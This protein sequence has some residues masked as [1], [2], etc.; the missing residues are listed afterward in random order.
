MS[1]D[2]ARFLE[3]KKVDFLR[4][5]PITQEIENVDAIPFDA[6]PTTFYQYS[7]SQIKNWF[8]R[9]KEAGLNNEL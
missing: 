7:A 9:R 6:N 1:E 4:E 5:Y 3:Q 2:Q 8:A